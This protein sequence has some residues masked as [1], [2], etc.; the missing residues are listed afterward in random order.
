LGIEERTTASESG[1][2]KGGKDA[3]IEISSDDF[4]EDD[5]GEFDDSLLPGSL[6]TPGIGT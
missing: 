3:P 2:E 4:I 1:D 6:A 5:G